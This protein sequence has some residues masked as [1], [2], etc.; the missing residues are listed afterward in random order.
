MAVSDAGSPR[1]LEILLYVAGNGP[2]STLAVEN[3]HHLCRGQAFGDRPFHLIDIAS[4]P[5]RALADKVFFTPMLVI[6]QGTVERRFVGNLSKDAAI[7]RALAQGSA[8]RE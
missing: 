6:R 1:D 8:R 4:D 3:L 5:A 2:N 7:I